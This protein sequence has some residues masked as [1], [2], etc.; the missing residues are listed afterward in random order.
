MFIQLPD[1]FRKVKKTIYHPGVGMSVPV[2]DDDDNSMQAYVDE[3]TEITEM[4]QQAF[5]AAV[6]QLDASIRQV[7]EM[8][9]GKISVAVSMGLPHLSSEQM[10][11]ALF[12]KRLYAAGE[13]GFADYIRKM[14]NLFPDRMEGLSE[15]LKIQVTER[16]DM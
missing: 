14:E 4:S 9:V 13:I 16:L 7:E 10:E 3:M 8:L 11:H 1:K 5:N 2:R 6:G 15:D 12:V